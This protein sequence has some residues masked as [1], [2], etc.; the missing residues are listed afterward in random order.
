MNSDMEEDM[1]TVGLQAYMGSRVLA[2]HVLR[3]GGE[4]LR[5]RV[6]SL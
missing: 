3:Q 2:P 5:C 4:K 6:F 1:R